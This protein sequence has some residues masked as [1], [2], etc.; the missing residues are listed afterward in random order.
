LG[1]DSGGDA[2]ARVSVDDCSGGRGIKHV[3][4]YRCLVEARCGEKRVKGNLGD[5]RNVI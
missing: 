3:I 2:S 4:G 5:L 1:E